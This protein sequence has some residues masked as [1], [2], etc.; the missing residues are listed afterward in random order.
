MRAPSPPSLLLPA[1]TALS[2]TDLRTG[3]CSGLGKTTLIRALFSVPGQELQLHDGTET[4]P[5]QFR[6]NPDSLCSTITWED[7]EDT[8]TW[9]YQASLSQTAGHN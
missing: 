7:E 8:T 9:V 6:K 5:E 2:Q 4:S 1:S 3:C